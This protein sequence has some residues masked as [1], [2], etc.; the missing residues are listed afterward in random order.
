M[1]KERGRESAARSVGTNTAVSGL[2]GEDVDDMWGI[3]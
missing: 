1:E 3:S 2:D